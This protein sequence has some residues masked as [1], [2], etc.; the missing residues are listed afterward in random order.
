[1]LPDGILRKK[2]KK[3]HKQTKNPGTQVKR[4]YEFLAEIQNPVLSK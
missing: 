2:K 4:I 1:M 3:S